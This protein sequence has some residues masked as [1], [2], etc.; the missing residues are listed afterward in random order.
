M[1]SAEEEQAVIGFGKIHN[2]N[3]SFFF[4]CVSKFT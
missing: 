2:L 4:C 3:F 1:S